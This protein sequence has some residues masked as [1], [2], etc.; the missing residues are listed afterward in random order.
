MLGLFNGAC[1]TTPHAVTMASTP[2][3]AQASVHP[4]RPGE[5]EP[6][7]VLRLPTRARAGSIIEGRV[8]VGSEVDAFGHRVA[9][10]A[11][12]SI[13]LQ[14]PDRPGIY[15][16]RILRAGA[17]SAVPLRIEVTAD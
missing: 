14:V 5:R 15:T 12:G 3:A 11:D 9:P 2:A 6:G 8:P 13:V 7:S 4:G 10:S 17:R 1:T 16:I